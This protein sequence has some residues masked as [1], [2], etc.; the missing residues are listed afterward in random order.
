MSG[1]RLRRQTGVMTSRLT[2][3]NVD[4]A[5]PVRLADFWCA[6]L[7]Y[8]VVL[9]EPDFIEIGP[10]GRSDADILDGRAPRADRAHAD[11]RSRA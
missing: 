2:E 4:C 11:L 1:G 3:T 6:A 7:G 5:D 10:A 9:T 8:V